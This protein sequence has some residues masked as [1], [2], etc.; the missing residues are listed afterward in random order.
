MN[1]LFT[2]NKFNRRQILSVAALSTAA[3]ALAYYAPRFL[4]K[5]LKILFESNSVRGH[6]MRENLPQTVSAKLN[7]DVDTL[8][9]GAGAAGL[10]AAYFLEKNNFK[11]YIV[12]EADSK[13]G[14]NSSFSEN[15]V[16][17]FPNGAHYLPIIR[18][19]DLELLDFLKQAGVVTGFQDQ[20]PIY[21]EEYL[22]HAPDERLF[23]KGR[24][25]ESLIPSFGLNQ[26]ELKQFHDFFN[27]T[28]ELQN[29][30]GR[31]GKFLFSIPV[32]RSSQDEEWL[33]LDKISF[34][35]FLIQK[36]WLNPAM[37]WYVNYCCRDDF[38]IDA[39]LTSAWAG[40]HYFCSRNGQAANA[41]AQSVLTWP[42]GN[43]FLIE[44]LNKKIT[45]PIK[46][47]C[48]VRSVNK[49]EKGY[50][51]FFVDRDMQVQR[52]NCKKII[53]A[54]P[55]SVISK[56]QPELNLTVHSQFN[57]W[58][59]VNLKVKKEVLETHSNLAWD[60]VRFGSDSLGYINSSH[61]LLVA[62]QDL[63][64]LTFYHAFSGAIAK[65][66][67]LKLYQASK[68]Q[69]LQIALDDI[70]KMHPE[71]SQYIIEAHIKVLGHGMVSPRVNY[72][73]QDRKSIADRNNS[74][75]I[76]A[77]TERSGI[78]IFEEAFHQGLRA[79]LVVLR[80]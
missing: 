47:E 27:Y 25:Q 28:H 29:K 34:T 14:G 59:L 21:N 69:L 38:G 58:V 77:H 5:K 70:S 67:R 30:K 80:G 22:C 18:N 65:E 78:S 75:I 17:K 54:V 71:I 48:T 6:I 10:S 62:E 3:L 20:L 24:W 16:S 23:I 2:H 42:E 63:V 60:N 52:V 50:E 8:I 66:E 68:E 43:A 33:K 40:L 49:T 79:A 45:Q 56:I 51:V 32:D 73:W 9:V 1:G 44:Y 4:A 41:Q 61:Q 11:N 74:T 13:I 26:T 12:L 7:T 53:Y 46:T 57:P 39:N 55:Q 76:M 19:D 64:N 36:E 72:I 15:D 37:N 35:D 31:D